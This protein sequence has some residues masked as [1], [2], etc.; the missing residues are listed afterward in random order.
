MT[1]PKEGGIQV[2]CSSSGWFPRPTLQWTDT[3]GRKLPSL[4]ESHTQQEDGLFHVDASLVVTD[5]SLG[6]LTC[7]IQNPL[8]GQEKTSTIFLPGVQGTTPGGPGRAGRGNKAEGNL[9]KGHGPLC[10]SL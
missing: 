9:G 6:N 4:P 8:S 3:T 10:A 5:S 7:S 1:G 2:L